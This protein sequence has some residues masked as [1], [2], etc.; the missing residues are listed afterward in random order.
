[1]MAPLDTPTATSSVHS[2]A[3]DLISVHT[4]STTNTAPVQL[5]AGHPSS[6]LAGYSAAPVDIGSISVQ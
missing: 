5:Q 4:T 3:V 6:L 1:M 2:Q